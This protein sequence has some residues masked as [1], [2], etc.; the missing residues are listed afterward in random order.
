VV[1]RPAEPADV[2]AWLDLF[3]G[4]VV[5]LASQGRTGQWGTEPMSARPGFRD[6][7]AGWVAAGH[8]RVATSGADV[9]GAAAFTV[10]PAYAPVADEPEIYIE[11][12]VVSRAPQARGA[13]RLLLDAAVGEA[14][15]QGLARVR[16]D[17]WA[18]GDGGLVRYYERCGFERAGELTVGSWPG[19]LLVQRL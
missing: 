8:G 19:Q 11:G 6:R 16:L 5:W 15:E 12:L 7:V 13:G 17:C 18:G 14:R 2:D 1:V 4:A 10:A 9:L 3:D